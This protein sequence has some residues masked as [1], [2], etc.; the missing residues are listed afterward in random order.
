MDSHTLSAFDRVRCRGGQ[1]VKHSLDMN[2]CV[3]LCVNLCMKLCVNLCVKPPRG[4]R[5]WRWRKL[6]SFSLFTTENCRCFLGFVSDSFCFYPLKYVILIHDKYK[7]FLSLQTL[8]VPVLHEIVLRTSD[9]CTHWTLR[10]VGLPGSS[11]GFSKVRGVSFYFSVHVRS[12]LG[13]CIRS[14]TQW[15]GHLWCR[16]SARLLEASGI[17]GDIFSATPPLSLP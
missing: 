11:H 10:V 2:L 4:K 7:I 3:K 5:V 14:W 13:S 16:R 17:V 6:W 1:G 8:R 15:Y 12:L 9:A